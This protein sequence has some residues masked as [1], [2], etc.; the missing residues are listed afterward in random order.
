MTLKMAC[1]CP[2][3]SMFKIWLKSND[4]YSIKNPPQ[5]SMTFVDFWLELMIIF[6]FL[7]G[8]GVLD[9]V[10]DG[11]HLP[12]GNYVKNLVEIC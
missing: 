7:T 8:N 4:F 5:R 11:L 9:D 2:E 1:T 3:G 6:M 10:L 12:R